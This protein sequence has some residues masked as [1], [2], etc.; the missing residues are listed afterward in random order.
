[1]IVGDIATVEV[2]VFVGSGVGVIREL[3]DWQPSRRIDRKNSSARRLRHLVFIVIPLTRKAHYFGIH[4]VTLA[5]I[6]MLAD[7]AFEYGSP[8]LFQAL[9]AQAVNMSANIS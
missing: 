1:V 7:K 8:D 4:S 6:A 3:G 9:K 2:S 5:V